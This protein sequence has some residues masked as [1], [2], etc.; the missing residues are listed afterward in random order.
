MEKKN[1][2]AKNKQTKKSDFF[3]EIGKLILEFIWKYK[4]PRIAKAI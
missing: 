4:G 2:K 1:P 3:A